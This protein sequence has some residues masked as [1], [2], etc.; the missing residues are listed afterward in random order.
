MVLVLAAASAAFISCGK[1]VEM[2]FG[3]FVEEHVENVAPL[4]KEGSIAYW[5]AAVSGAEE[6]FRRYSDIRLE[7]EKIYSDKASFEIVRQV[8]DSG[9]L[10]EPL[11]RRMA[12]ILYL[13]YLGN[14]AD[15]RLLERIVSLSAKVENRFNVF[16][17]EV[18]GEKLTTNDVC[19]VL[20]ESV[21]GGYRR[22]VWESSKAVGKVVVEDLLE[23]VRL[24][25]ETAREAGF[26]NY[27]SMSLAVGEQDEEALA[28]LFDELDVLTS[29]PFRKLKEEIDDG[30]AKQFGIAPGDIRPWHYSDPFFQEAPAGEMAGLDSLFKGRDIVTLAA[31]FY[32]SI[33]MPVGDVIARSDLYEKEGKNP[34]AFC[35]DIDR[36]GDIRILCNVKDNVYWME[37]MLHELGHAVY[38]KYIQRE[39]PW[40]LRS[41]PHLATTEASA[42]YFGRLAQDPRWISAVLDL[43]A[44]ETGRLAPAL[45]R[46]LRARQLIFT[47]WT[48]VMFRFERELYRDPDGDLNTVW[49]DLVEKYQLVRR[50]DGRDQPDWAAKIH[51]VSSPVYYHNY[52]LGEMI[53]SQ[54]HH[55]VVTM[56]EG[57][58]D[59]G[60]IYGNLAAG[61]FFRDRVYRQG[62]SA[63]WMEHIEKVTGEPLHAKYFVEQFVG[64]YVEG[65]V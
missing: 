53:A 59:A 1:D 38:D 57:E 41:Y 25:N 24:R 51:I 27:H 9:M 8:R 28:A 35:T 55:H 17:A 5:K 60:D 18:D 62:N 7:M 29:E 26:D 45:E 16:R 47:R 20:R 61:E 30:L 23:L 58:A 12:D 37:T 4:E 36:E 3:T 43:N 31:D 6:D 15:P 19:G 14:Q 44:D 32:E 42:M 39:L 56:I 46:S 64:H 13:R 10:K 11:L 63:P 33:G 34:H 54:L 2:E 49:W 52:M 65:G 48:Q 21:D 22:A 40:L 50:P